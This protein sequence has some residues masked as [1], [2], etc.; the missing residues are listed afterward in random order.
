MTE[1]KE[2]VIVQPHYNTVPSNTKILSLHWR[3]LLM[4]KQY[5]SHNS[6]GGHFRLFF[7]FWSFDLQCRYSTYDW[8][9]YNQTTSRENSLGHK[10]VFVIKL[11]VFG[12]KKKALVGVSWPDQQKAFFRL[13]TYQALYIRHE[14]FLPHEQS[15]APHTNSSAQCSNHY[16]CYH[17]LIKPGQGIN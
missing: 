16:K 1:T 5:F 15:N 8:R 11:Q 12:G 10:N 6:G 7:F 14:T 2:Y 17:I 9:R 3:S 4:C 13:T